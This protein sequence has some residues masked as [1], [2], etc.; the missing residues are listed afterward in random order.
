[1]GEARGET[2]GCGEGVRDGAIDREACAEEVVEALKEPLWEGLRVAL[3][4]PES[5]QQE[6]LLAA[7]ASE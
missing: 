6:A 1:M 3:P 5:S 4:L 7:P 2:L